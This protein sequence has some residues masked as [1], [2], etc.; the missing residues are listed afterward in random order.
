MGDEGGRETVEWSRSVPV[1]YESDVAVIGGGIAGACAACAAA[2]SGAS[3][4]LVERFAVPGGMLTVGGVHNFCGETGGQGEVFD[5][6]VAGLDAFGGI[7]PY[8]PYR[9]F[10]VRRLFHGGLLAVVLQ[11]LLLRRGV[12]L[13]LH[14]RFVDV[15]LSGNR[16]TECIVRGPSG[17][18][19]LRAKQFI[20]CTGEAEVAH[21]A[22]FETMKGRP[23][24]GRQLPMSILFFVRELDGVRPQVP[25]GWCEPIRPGDDLPMISPW[26]NGP[27]SKA[28]KVKVSGYDS[29]DTE[30]LTAAETAA[31]RRIIQVLDYLQRVERKPWYFDRA[32]P[33]IA[34]REGRRIVGDYVLTESDV[35]AGRTFDDGVAVGTFYIDAHDPTTDARAAQIAD[36]GARCVPP[37][38]IP[39][40]SL[41]ARDGA[42]LWMAGRCLSADTMAHA[43][44]RVAPT[45]AMMGQAVGTAA[46]LAAA[47]DCDARDVDPAEV[48]R[49]VI[50]RGGRLDLDRIGRP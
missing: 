17:P 18:E 10:E 36:P 14:T 3:V 35:R 32:S 25:E 28:I 2:R 23:A 33:T 27:R 50:E 40:R 7:Q 45:G 39:L 1:R 29:T 44:A 13:L 21:L 49:I 15:R 8:E 12:K 9:H 37:Y 24:D 47:G 16:I 38:H 46:R 48:H 31:R 22:G 26:R 43:S 42:N 41:T 20:D 34:I 4:I 19:A 11:E 6:I 5:E 30:S